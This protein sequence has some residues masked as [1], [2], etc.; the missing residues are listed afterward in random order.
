MEQPDQQNSAEILANLRLT[1]SEV[2]ISQLK[3]DSKNPRTHSEGQIKRVAKN[4]KKFGFLFPILVD[5]NGRVIAGHAR[6]RAMKRLGRS[7]VP[8]ICISH[9]SD[10]QIRAVMIADNK[11]SELASWDEHLLAEQFKA[12]SEVELDFDLDDIGFEVAEIDLLIEGLSAQEKTNSDSADELPES[13][14]IQVARPGDLFLLG[15]NRV[16]CADSLKT[17]SYAVLMQEHKAAL[18]FTDPP[19]NVHISGHASGL[20]RIQHKDFKMASGEM[21]EAEFINFLSTIGNLLVRYSQRGSVHFICMDWRHAHELLVAGREAYDS[22]LNIC[23][24]AK[25]NGGMGSLYRS[26]HE[27]VFVYKNGKCTHRNNVELGRHG[28]YR[29][30]VWNYPGAN[31]FSRTTEEGDLLEFH[32][33]VKPVAM[34][35][36][37]ILD[38]SAL[39]DIVLD[40]FLGSGTTVIAAERTGRVCFGLE[41]DPNY[42]DVI[43]RRWQKFTGLSATLAASGRSFNDLEKEAV[44]ATG[45]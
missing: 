23:I 33:T 14:P 19:F 13:N 22:L 1:V 24:W 8:T 5:A 21:S 28:R 42:V 27:F 35:A 11:L 18:V 38:V 43:V 44:D 40:P 6:I 31:S 2:P 45:R 39:G 32:P 34:V 7:S 36:D 12:L 41:I 20:G 29:T 10:T 4:I 15:R 16:Y 26:Q 9:L 37:A 17:N 3:P 30:N 25:T